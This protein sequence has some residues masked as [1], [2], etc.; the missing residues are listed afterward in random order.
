[1]YVVEQAARKVISNLD[2][3][4][5]NEWNKDVIYIVVVV[6]KRKWVGL[7]IYR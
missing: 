1:M 4:K 3:I 6:V 5:E 2:Q 7:E